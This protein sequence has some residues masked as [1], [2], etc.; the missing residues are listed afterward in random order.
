MTSQH[1][2]SKKTARML[3]LLHLQ[4]AGVLG[5]LNQSE[6]ARVLKVNRSTIHRDFQ[7]L[8]LVDAEYRRLM[9]TQPWVKR[10]LTV[11]EFAE[12]IGAQP[13]TVRCLLRDGLIPAAKRPGPGP[14]GRWL[15]PV[16]A[17]DWWLRPQK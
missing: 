14:K 15:I 10:E 9:A 16:T 4:A 3:L 7:D 11:E 5:D 2:A 8:P 17:L 6:I 1:R 12:K 13:E